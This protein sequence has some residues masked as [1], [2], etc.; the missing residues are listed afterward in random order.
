MRKIVFSLAVILL[1]LAGC[2]S[3][4]AEQPVGHI[5]PKAEVSLDL[6]QT[7]EGLD[8]ATF[9]GEV[10]EIARGERAFLVSIGHTPGKRK[11]MVG[12]EVWYYAISETQWQRGDVA[13]AGV[14]CFGELEPGVHVDLLVRENVALAVHFVPKA[15]EDE[16]GR[17]GES[18]SAG[19]ENGQGQP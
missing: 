15:A 14:D 19:Q 1:L 10:K 17:G 6:P 18:E 16:S 7:R 3:K 2:G 13:V 5:P 12:R 4:K 11:D 8:D 9:S